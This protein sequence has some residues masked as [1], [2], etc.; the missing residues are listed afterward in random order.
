MRNL[1]SSIRSYSNSETQDKSGYSSESFEELIIKANSVKIEEVIKYYNPSYIPG[2]R[3]INCL[4]HK[5]GLET[6]PSCY[7]Y[8]ETNSFWCFA[9]NAGTR[10]VDLVVALEKVSRNK[11]AEKILSSFANSKPI[12]LKEVDSLKENLELNIKFSNFIREARSFIFYDKIEEI[13]ETFDKISISHNLNNYS[14]NKLIEK[15]FDKIK[16]YY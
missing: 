4:I 9:C 2:N 15:L 13:C 16:K 12:L 3:K 11:A 14:L 7:V 5:N 6:T 8:P 10:P 1:S